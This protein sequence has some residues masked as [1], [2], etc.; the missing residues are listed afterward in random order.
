MYTCKRKK[1]CTLFISTDDFVFTIF[2]GSMIQN[3]MNLN[4]RKSHSTHE[5]TKF[6]KYGFYCLFFIAQQQ[7]CLQW[8]ILIPYYSPRNENFEFICW[9]QILEFILYLNKNLKIYWSNKILLLLG[10]MT[11]VH[12][13]DCHKESFKRHMT[14][15][16]SGYSNILQS[17]HESHFQHNLHFCFRTSLLF[18][19]IS[20]LFKN[21]CRYDIVLPLQTYVNGNTWSI[22]A[23]IVW[24]L[25]DFLLI[26]KSPLKLTAVI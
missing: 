19:F 25:A 23:A 4:E 18:V 22:M 15:I 16:L 12:R 9:N 5:K 11:G 8:Q 7:L 24:G 10:W 17:H 1:C 26:L 13:V 3:N 21:C 14:Y 2:K 20:T 6:T